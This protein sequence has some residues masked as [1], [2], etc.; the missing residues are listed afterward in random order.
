MNSP[1]KQRVNV[2]NV[3]FGVLFPT[4]SGNRSNEVGGLSNATFTHTELQ[5]GL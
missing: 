4:A 3:L 2:Q 1:M 5:P